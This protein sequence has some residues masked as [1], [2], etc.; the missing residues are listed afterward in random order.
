MA[1][2]THDDFFA[3]KAKGAL[4]DIGV[5][6]NRTN[7]L[8][9]D[10]NAVFETEAELD[11]YIS[12]VLSYPGQPVAV[13]SKTGTGTDNDPYVYD[14][15]FYVLGYDEKG[16]L[17]KQQ[18]GKATQGDDASIVL[19]KENGTLSLKDFTAANSGKLASISLVDGKPVLTWVSNSQEDLNAD[20]SGIHQNINDLQ[21]E[22]VKINTRIDNLGTV[23]NFVGSLSATDFAGTT[24]DE[25]FIT[26]KSGYSL[27]SVVL[28]EGKEYVAVNGTQYKLTEDT[29]ISADKNYY[30]IIDGSYVL[31][32]DPATSNPQ[33]DGYYEKREGLV[34][35][36]FGDPDGVSALQS[37]V[38]TLQNDV[39]TNAGGINS[40]K[41]T[42]EKHTTTL[43]EHAA[44]IAN[45]AEQ[46][47]LEALSTRVTTAE[48][49]ID[50]LET[51][52][53]TQG[54]SITSTANSLATLTA[55]FN[56]LKNN[57]VASLSQTVQGN[58]KDIAENAEKISNLDSR[59]TTNETAIGKNAEAA[60]NAQS[61]ADAAMPKTGGTFTG[62]ISWGA[63]P[64][65]DSH[66]ANKKYVDDKISGLSI[67]NYATTEYV[68][69]Q[70]TTV[71]G[72]VTTAQTTADNAVK[73]ASDAQNTADTNTSSINT[74]N[75][76]IGALDTS[77]GDNIVNYIDKVSAVANNAAVK[78]EVDSA[79]ATLTA[80]VSENK[81]GVTEA[82]EAASTAETNAK[83]YTDN[84]VAAAKSSI[85]GTSNS[86]T[87]TTIKGLE[88]DIDGQIAT[89]N[90][91]LDAIRGNVSSLSNVMN[92]VGVS[93]TDPAEAPKADD[94][95]TD[96]NQG[97]IT[98][99]GAT[100]TPDIGDV[101]IYSGEEYVYTG[102]AWEQFGSA[103][104]STAAIET[105][106][107][108]IAA[109]T[110]AIE[111]NDGD[112]TALQAADGTLQS[113]IDEVDGKVT[114]LT[115]RVEVNEG[116]IAANAKAI[117]EEAE[118][119]RAA[120]KDNADNIAA[121]AETARAAEKTLTTA[122]QALEA[123]L[124]WGS[125]DE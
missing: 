100:Y 109:N 125:F 42:V 92:F 74:I 7:P 106:E 79:I 15:K 113:N 13:I 22:D 88:D 105:I 14:T 90:S 60:A 104:A 26:D 39:A 4:W 65:A 58:V 67:S 44:S 52:T 3:K 10:K 80:G 61:T 119:A 11:T 63:V 43:E 75:S 37:A 78:S 77:K 2:I 38:Q 62:S 91:S 122:I 56:T 33:A 1:S 36:A 87:N 68:D 59:V 110:E 34:W 64:T 53:T 31:V 103:D 96:V 20:L 116:N 101:V 89:I 47:D 50:N 114:A 82:K 81:T 24:D 45:K 85:I 30:Q 121:E 28:V 51:L 111:S 23:L 95:E 69:Q 73:A 112:I 29:T 21:A 71:T 93:S 9:L 86:A 48:Q 41:G 102:T 25:N 40:L 70:I 123:Q 120:E 115:S 35:E 99:N 66:L 98:V 5:S 6:I 16:V 27:G 124:T 12:G 84:Q 94:Q 8:P 57:T 18:V 49:D 76:T 19:D 83:K 108:K 117:A 97:D 118:K 32:T 54:T 46:A 72:K 107:A 17:S 55:D